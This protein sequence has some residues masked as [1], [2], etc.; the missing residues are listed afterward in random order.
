[1]NSMSV[2]DIIVLGGSAGG[3]EPL[4]TVVK[5]LPADLPAA[6]FV[7]QHLSPNAH[8]A[9]PLI[10]AR[11]G[12]LPCAHA[13]DG[14][15]IHRGRIYIAPP[16][17]HMLITNDRVRLTRGPRE[18]R[19]RPAVDP[20]FR[21]AARW[22]GP[23]VVGVVLSGALNDGTAGLLAIK[24]CGGVTVVQDPKEALFSGM[25]QSAL[26]HVAADH[27]LAAAEIGA[28]LASIAGEP[29]SPAP[30]VPQ[31][32]LVEDEIAEGK[33]INVAEVGLAAPT[34]LVCPDCGG[35]LNQ[36]LDGAPLQ[37]LRCRVGHAH[38][39]TTL[40]SAKA[41]ALEAALWEALRSQG[42]R[43]EIY[44]RLAAQSNAQGQLSM[45]RR[46][47]TRAEELEKHAAIIQELLISQN[48]AD[49]NPDLE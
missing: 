31:D 40:G 14:E 39:L 23:R 20:L 17:H 32:V 19:V 25:P 45:A 41:E 27:C 16:E 49:T 7:V 22:R 8:S 24:R 43:V 13:K 18:N 12:K 36:M 47:Q 28:L 2:L 33:P 3:V 30:P 38:T 29:V 11:S 6:L 1:M 5:H 34:G 10:L 15:P 48:I 4:R 44:Q 21:S 26:D 9:L 42:E 46:W 35:A 37:R